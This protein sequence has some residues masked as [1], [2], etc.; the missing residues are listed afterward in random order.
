[1]QKE[2]VVKAKKATLTL[3][4]EPELMAE[5]EKIKLSTL[6]MYVIVNAALAFFLKQEPGV[7][8]QA[9]LD[10]IRDKK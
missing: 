2:K 9:Q 6:P 8:I 10:Y 5:A 1:M 3:Y 4:T 7:R